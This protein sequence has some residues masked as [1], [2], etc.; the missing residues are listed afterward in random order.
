[1]HAQETQYVRSRILWARVAVAQSVSRRVNGLVSPAVLVWLENARRTLAIT[2]AEGG[3]VM[4]ARRT[5]FVG[6]S[7]HIHDPPLRPGALT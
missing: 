6:R 3:R 4:K 1:M 5:P 7:L 2:K